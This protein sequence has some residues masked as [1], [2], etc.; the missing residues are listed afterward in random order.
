MKAA[1]IELHI[2]PLGERIEGRPSLGEVLLE[3]VR[4]RAEAREASVRSAAKELISHEVDWAVFAGWTFVAERVPDWLAEASRNCTIAIELVHPDPDRDLETH[5]LQDGIS[6]IRSPQRMYTATD[7]TAALTNDLQNGS[8]RFTDGLLWICGEVEILDGGKQG[9]MSVR[10]PNDLSEQH[11]RG[12]V[13]L[14][15]AH[16]AEHLPA[17]KGKR[18]WLSRNGWLLRAANTHSRGWRYWDYRGGPPVRRTAHA[19]HRGAFAWRRKR[20][21]AAIDRIELGADGSHIS[22]FQID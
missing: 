12:R 13:M 6:V 7:D 5:V 22:W 3:T 14:N 17:S 11:L 20:D 16:T 1:V 19:S 10:V 4:R 15:V 2:D 8:R 21:R 9:P 18:A